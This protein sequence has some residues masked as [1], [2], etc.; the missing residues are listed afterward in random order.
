M[1]AGIGDVFETI[2]SMI[3]EVFGY[4]ASHGG[5][6]AG[7]AMLRKV[8]WA[9]G[10]GGGRRGRMQNHRL[11]GKSLSSGWG[12]GIS[13]EH[14]DPKRAYEHATRDCY[15]QAMVSG[16]GLGRKLQIRSSGYNSG[17][18]HSLRVPPGSPASRLGNYNKGKRQVNARGGGL[19]QSVSFRGTK[20]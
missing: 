5:K 1:S 12:G 20:Y 11:A 10:G 4:G 19:K 15:K 8:G 3:T 16:S 14:Y 9:K 6:K 13:A 17:P 2:M 7:L 18:G